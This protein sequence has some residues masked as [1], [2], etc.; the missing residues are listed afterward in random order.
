[1][2]IGEI[3]RKTGLSVDAVRFYERSLLLAA[4][5][6]TLGGFRQYGETDVETLA[7]IHRAKDLGF[8]LKEIRELSRLR[9]ARL[10]SCPSVRRRLEKKLFSVREKMADL[11][12]LETEL[13]RALRSCTREMRKRVPRCPLL[14]SGSSAKPETIN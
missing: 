7:F 4:P 13:Q 1:M 14:R 12:R 8:T 3:A 9:R 10:Q 6:R 5:R 11:Q 2:H